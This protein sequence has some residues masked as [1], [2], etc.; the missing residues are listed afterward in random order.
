ME[1]TPAYQHGQ[2]DVGTVIVLSA[3][4]RHE[5]KWKRPAAGQTG[6]T[7][8][9]LLAALHAVDPISFPSTDKDAYRIINAT[10]RV[11][12]GVTTEADRAE[13][14]APINLQRLR[15]GV[16]GKLVVVALGAKA[17]STL[18]A[19]KVAVTFAAPHPSMQSLNRGYKVDGQ[20]PG[21]RAGQRVA[22]FASDLL[23]SRAAQ[24]L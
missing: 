6:R 9:R 1:T 8:N 12:Y 24:A 18:E 23:A 19:A 10:S 11:H 5:E 17:R 15:D 22:L 2:D 16:A 13:L 7:L 3:P 20:T 14:E 4:G 21:A